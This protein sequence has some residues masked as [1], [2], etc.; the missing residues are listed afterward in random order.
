MDIAIIGYGRMGKEIEAVAL[1]RGHQIVLKI[2]QEN[3]SAFTEANL[4]MADVA[5]EFSRPESA[6]ENV[7]KCLTCHLPVVSG[8]TAW[9]SNLEQAR[10]LCLEKETAFIHASNFSL[11]VNLFFELNQHLAKLMGTY[12]QYA[13]SL[14][15]THHL[16]KKDKPSG[17]AITLAEQILELRKDKKA[18]VLE[19]EQTEENGIPVYA[20]REEGVPGTHEIVYRSV[21]DEIEIKHTAFSRK[22]FAL[23]AVL[24]AEFIIDKKGCFSMKDVLGL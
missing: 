2:N 24:A 14:K 1:E 7:S 23:G 13:V 20:H 15:E 12:P 17:T 11:G 18:W 22:G 9:Q 10:Q 19:P 4:R 6:F 3:L 5:I 8:T 21:I 16:E